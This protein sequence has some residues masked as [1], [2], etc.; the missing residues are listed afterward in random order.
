V[1][2]QLQFLREFINHCKDDILLLQSCIN[3]LLARLADDN[4]LVKTWT[5]RGLSN[6]ISAGKVEV[7][8][9]SSTILTAMMS[10]LDGPSDNIA[11]EAL[12][13]LDK[14]LN[15]VDE[16]SVAPIL[17]NL[18]LRIRPA[19]EKLNDEIRAAAFELFGGLSKFGRDTAQ[20]IFREQIHDSLVSFLLH[21]NDDNHLVRAACKRS[22]RKLCDLLQS[23][24][25][26]SVFNSKS[27]DDNMKLDYDAFLTELSKKLINNFHDRINFYVMGCVNFYQSNWEAIKSNAAYF[28]GCLLV[29][30]PK[31]KRGIINREHVCSELVKLLKEKDT[32]VRS[33]TADAL[34]MLYDY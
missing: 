32:N 16:T 2:L 9:F 12:R 31:A 18:C 29:S 27:F 13:G 3:C 8:K 22:L 10:G 33:R 14:V 26:N 6:I 30:L 21:T 34:A 20:D 25:V 5:L 17:V 24:E 1:S 19:F 15:V 7:N 11:L 28:T 4:E 23:E